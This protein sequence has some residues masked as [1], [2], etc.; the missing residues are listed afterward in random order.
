M[1]TSP[2]DANR[3]V[4]FLFIWKEKEVSTGISLVKATGSSNCIK[5][6]RGGID[7]R[8]E[9]PKSAATLI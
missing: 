1:V 3:A 7:C 2:I 4:N 6:D 8:V 9:Q 5:N